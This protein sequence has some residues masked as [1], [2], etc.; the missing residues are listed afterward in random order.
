MMV[1]DQGSDAYVGRII[2]SM[3]CSNCNKECRHCG[4]GFFGRRQNIW[5]HVNPDGSVASRG[6]EMREMVLG[7]IVRQA[8]QVSDWKKYYAGPMKINGI[9]IEDVEAEIQKH[10]QTC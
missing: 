6:K 1:I 8:L 9:S 10:R 7:I 4:A 2:M 5:Q 3:K